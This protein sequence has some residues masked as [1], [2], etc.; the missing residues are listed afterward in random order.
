MEAQ[1]VSA[2]PMADTDTDTRQLEPNTARETNVLG[3]PI[4][5][6]PNGRWLPGTR[7]Q[8]LGRI[9]KK[10]TVF[11]ETQKLATRRRKR[12]AKAWVDTMEGT[13]AAANRARADYNDRDIGT[14]AHRMIV[15]HGEVPADALYEEIRGMLTGDLPRIETNDTDI[16]DDDE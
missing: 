5:R 9:P 8:P 12:I 4:A 3:E 10:P 7:P 6:Q 16:V 15:A 14:V 11:E 2:K 1:A 13:D